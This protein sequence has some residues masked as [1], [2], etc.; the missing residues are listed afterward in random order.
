MS[1]KS[2]SVQQMFAYL[3]DITDA[4]CVIEYTFKI[5]LY[6][7]IYIYVYMII[8]IVYTIA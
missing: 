3:C 8:C 6:I 5:Y 4:V 7:T 1:G 2:R